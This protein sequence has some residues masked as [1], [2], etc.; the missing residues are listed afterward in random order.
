MNYEKSECCRTC[1][2]LILEKYP[3]LLMQNFVEKK[4]KKADFTTSD[5]EVEKSYTSF[6]S[7]TPKKNLMILKID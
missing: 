1:E 7:F 5:S 2:Q 3:T 4:K 6:C